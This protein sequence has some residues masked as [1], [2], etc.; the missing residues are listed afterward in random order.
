MT[1]KD[2]L[3]RDID[4]LKESIRLGF[5]ANSNGEPGAAEHLRWCLD[6]LREL[7]K[8]LEAETEK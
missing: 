5:Q 2:K 3:I 4:T 8:Q 6:E 7:V 1:T